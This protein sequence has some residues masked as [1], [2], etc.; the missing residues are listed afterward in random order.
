M[1]SL[2]RTRV[3]GLEPCPKGAHTRLS[4]VPLQVCLLPT[5]AIWH[6]QITQSAGQEGERGSCPEIQETGQAGLM[7]VLSVDA[8]EGR[9]H[10]GSGGGS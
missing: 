8:C 10:K 1:F 5:R 9:V 6:T 7:D 2:R 4:P 3:S